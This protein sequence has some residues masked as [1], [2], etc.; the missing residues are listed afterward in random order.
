MVD[1][2]SMVVCRDQDITDVLTTD[3]DFEREGFVALLR[4]G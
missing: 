2:I 4:D 3:R 1:C